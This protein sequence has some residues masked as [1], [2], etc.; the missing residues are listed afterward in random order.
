MNT[1]T[2]TLD[3]PSADATTP[4]GIL[5]AFLAAWWHGNVGEAAEQFSDRFTFTDHALGLEFKDKEPQGLRVTA[6]PRY[7]RPAGF[8][9]ESSGPERRRSASWRCCPWTGEPSRVRGTGGGA[10]PGS[11]PPFAS[12]HGCH[13]HGSSR[14]A[15][16]ASCSRSPSGGATRGRSISRWP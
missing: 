7:R 11:R 3:N 15:A 4:N 14:R 2:T 6:S 5:H 8:L 13:P 10:E 12:A 16:N 9:R 1:Q